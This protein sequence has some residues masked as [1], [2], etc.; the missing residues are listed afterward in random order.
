M[1]NPSPSLSGLPQIY[2]ADV[3]G[4]DTIQKFPLGAIGFAYGGNKGFRYGRNNASTA[5]V[6]G[7]LQ[8][9]VTVTANHVNRA[10]DAAVAVDALSVAFTVGAT[11][12]AKDLY[13][14][15]E[16]CIND[17]GSSTGEGIS[18]RIRGNTA[19]ASSG[20][21]TVFLDEPVQVAMTTSTEVSLV[22]N[23][24]DRFVISVTDQADQFVGVANKAIAVD[25]YAWLQTR[26]LCATQADETL[27][28]GAALT[29]G[30][31]TAGQVEELDGVLEPRLGIAN[32][33]GVDTEE[34]LVYLTID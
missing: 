34:R 30:T 12:A 6:A 21:G 25:L 22:Q 2:G 16:L 15:G 9:A 33:A 23:P 1:A 27:T 11:A 29:T 4:Q 8:V 18:Y 28:V 7:Q 19:F 13:A 10:L 31:G 26:G 17:A 20:A 5:A 3:Y 24:W 32:Q 14:E